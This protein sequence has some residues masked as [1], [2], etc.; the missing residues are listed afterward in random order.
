VRD[1]FRLMIVLA[2]ICAVAG[3]LL[4]YVD[5]FTAPKIAE[6]RKLAETNAYHEALPD[7]DTFESLAP[8]QLSRISKNPDTS[9]ILEVKVGK[10]AGSLVGWICKVVAHG[11]SSDI[12]LLV[13]IGNDAQ[14][15]GVVILEQNETPGLGSKVSEAEFIGQD[16][17]TTAKPQKDLRVNKDGGE[18]QAVAGATI[19]SRAVLRGIN[20]AFEF[21]RT[22]LPQAQ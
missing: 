8:E 2:L 18:V 14:L 13:G 21:Y 5:S 11:Y 19:S 7:A 1:Y 17:I 10:K 6:Y 3:G 15:D 4:A 20:Q 9:G 22:A 16:A 12:K